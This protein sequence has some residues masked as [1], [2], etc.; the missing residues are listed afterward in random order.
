[1]DP[2]ASPDQNVDETRRRAQTPQ[3]DIRA[4]KNENLVLVRDQN[5]RT[6][7]FLLV[8]GKKWWRR[9]LEAS[10]PAS[11]QKTSGAT[12]SLPR[13]SPTRVETCTTHLLT[14]QTHK[15]DLRKCT[16]RTSLRQSRAP[17]RT[18]C[19]HNRSLRRKTASPRPERSTTKTES[20]CTSKFTGFSNPAVNGFALVEF[21][22]QV[23]AEVEN[24]NAIVLM[25]RE[26]L[27]DLA[28]T[29]EPNAPTQ[30]SIS[31]VSSVW[32]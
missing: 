21:A 6:T 17:A 18:I 7:Q 4:A 11:L 24:A 3:C 13:N 19:P 27:A 9:R 20:P 32:S 8:L 1:M 26:D 22:Q 31:S 2:T 25:Q 14:R 10:R 15:A 5:C 23:T 12:P 28:V 30:R 16:W 29:T